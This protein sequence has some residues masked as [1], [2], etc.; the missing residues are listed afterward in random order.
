MIENFFEEF[1]P[2]LAFVD[3]VMG[4]NGKLYAGFDDKIVKAMAKLCGKADIIV[5]NMTEAALMLGEE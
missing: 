1:K 4:D 3:P 2:G 5:P